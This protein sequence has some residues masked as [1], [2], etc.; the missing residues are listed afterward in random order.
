MMMQALNYVYITVILIAF[1]SSLIAFR[2]DLPFHL[3]LF[4]CLLGLTFI[5]E[6]FV[7]L[8]ERPIFHHRNNFWIYNSF[9]LVEFWLYGYFFYRI[10]T[11]KA[12]RKVIFLFLLIFPIFWVITI[13]FLFGFNVWN[14]YVVIVGSFF[15]VIFA[16][17]YYYQIITAKE[18]RSLRSMPEFWIATGLLIFYLGELPFFGVL[19][20][21]VSHDMLLTRSLLKVLKLLDTLMYGLFSYGFLC[22]IINT[23]K[24]SS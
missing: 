14:S 12:L 16:I 18:I 13:F 8:F 19:N 23:R 6:C 17:M 11:V 7:A 3:K 22:L 20:F 24:S 21:L 4:S 9:G 5:I 1:I 2:L 10:I 15:S